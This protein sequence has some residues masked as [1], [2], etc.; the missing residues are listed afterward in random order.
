MTMF[1]L[2]LSGDVVQSINPFTAFM[3]GGQFGLIN[4]NIGQTDDENVEKEVLTDVAGYGMQLGRI[5]DVLVVLLRHF[6]P[7]KPLNGEESA[8]IEALTKMLDRIAEKKKKHRRPVVSTE[9]I[10]AKPKPRSAD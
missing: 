4:I 6:R 2:P 9:G 1:K 8:A 10:A 5:E 7:E 3:T